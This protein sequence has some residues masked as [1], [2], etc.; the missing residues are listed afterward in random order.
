M[1]ALTSS[2]SLS[3]SRDVDTASTAGAPPSID[4]AHASSDSASIAPASLSGEGGGAGQAL[5]ALLHGADQAVRA[6]AVS[7]MGATPA[8][9]PIVSAADA[10]DVDQGV[11]ESK[12]EAEPQAGPGTPAEG[13]QQDLL[14]ALGA[15][16]EQPLD[17]AEAS[18]NATVAGQ[19]SSVAQA[20]GATSMDGVEADAAGDAATVAATVDENESAPPT[21][22]PGVDPD[23]F[24]QL[25]PEMQQELV[26]EHRRTLGSMVRFM[27]RDLEVTKV[28]RCD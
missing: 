26:R 24:G 2:L 18:D 23:V 10:M 6:A 28:V 15:S 16:T 1:A 17:T 21:C 8:P 11:D 25:P 20:D 7:V 9:A 14:G 19:E 22:P 3:P 13:E 27:D 5:A 12:G 4:S